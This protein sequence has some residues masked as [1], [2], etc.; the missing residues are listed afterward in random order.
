M[1]SPVSLAYAA[2]ILDA[3]GVQGDPRAAGLR[4]IGSTLYARL[5]PDLRSP[6]PAGTQASDD[7]AL[8]AFPF[9]AAVMPA[10]NALDQPGTLDDAALA[11]FETALAR[12]D[13][14]ITGSA[15]P[16]YLRGE[17]RIRRSRPAEARAFFETSLARLPGF[18]PSALKLS[19][20]IIAGGSAPSELPRLQQLAAAL[21]TPAMRLAALSRAYLAA[22]KPDEAA[23]AAAQGL[24]L[25]AD[26]ARFA[27]LRAQALDAQG[28]WYQAV[29]VLDALL[30]RVPDDSEAIL[31]KARILHQQGGNSAEA[32]RL[33]EDAQSRFPSDPSFPELRGRILLEEGR[34]EECAAAL[35][36]ALAIEPARP[37]TLTL[38]LR[39]AVQNGQWEEASTFLDRIPA[40]A[41]STDD[42]R[43][44][45]K[46]ATG[47]GDYSRAAVFARF[48]KARGGGAAAMA[49]ESRSLNAAGFPARALA[50]IDAALP[51]AGDALR[52]ELYTIRAQAG[53][54]DP[55]GD[56]RHALHYNPDNIE[57]LVSLSDL[58][59]SQH[60]FRRAAAYAR[61]AAGLSPDDAGLAQRARDLDA[62]AS[63]EE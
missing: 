21:P 56:L 33:M 14:L 16:P 32:L 49:L 50:E 23:D 57:A 10:L 45:W 3:Q 40:S 13:V 19:G 39:L 34:M 6:F 63:P 25:V 53:S 38:L 22:G 30:Q 4:H 27:L 24:L 36:E 20:L 35:A 43:L 17:I 29:R 47:L 59:A 12:A 42:L 28:N 48:L 11:S 1:G 7:A 15:L 5:F 9:L 61:H 54:T 60:D 44:G 51:Q 46:L 26:D 31:E 2:R 62:L 37:S 55:A 58:L 41:R 18:Y 52:S 8:A